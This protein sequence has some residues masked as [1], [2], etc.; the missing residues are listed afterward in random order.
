MD[1]DSCQIQGISSSCKLDVP[2]SSFGTVFKQKS[3]IHNVLGQAAMCLC[4]SINVDRPVCRSGR[5]GLLGS[6]DV[7]PLGDVLAHEVLREE[8]GI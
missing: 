5:D 4:I 7:L 8:E 1:L 2:S 6:D 3:F